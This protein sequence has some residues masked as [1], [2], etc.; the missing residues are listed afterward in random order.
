MFCSAHQLISF[1]CW[2]AGA[3]IIHIVPQVS[4]PEHVKSLS[5]FNTAVLSSLLALLSLTFNFAVMVLMTARKDWLT[6][7]KTDDT[8]KD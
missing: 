5:Q 4:K 1:V 2:K 6:L 7:G 3:M 8:G